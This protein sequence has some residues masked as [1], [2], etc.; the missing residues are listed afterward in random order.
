MHEKLQQ[1]RTDPNKIT[2]NTATIQTIATATTVIKG[3]VT[4]QQQRTIINKTIFSTKS[5]TKQQ[6]QQQQKNPCNPINA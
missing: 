4:Q 3:K 2:K 5:L 6:V 1:K